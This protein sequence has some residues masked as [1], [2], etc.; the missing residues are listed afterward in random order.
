MVPAPQPSTT[1][2]VGDLRK[3]AGFWLKSLRK[4]ARL[5]QRA[6]A[7]EVGFTYY[8]TIAQIEAGKLRLQPDRCEAYARALGVPDSQE[9]IKQLM[10]YY[11]PVTHRALF[12]DDKA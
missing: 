5:S 2:G 11:D 1:H 8:T 9:F 3:E 10:S 6:L 12:G 7:Q 4:K